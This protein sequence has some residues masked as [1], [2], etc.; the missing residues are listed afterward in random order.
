MTVDDFTA[1]FF[2]HWATPVMIGFCWHENDSN[3]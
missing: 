2:G 1:I 3:E